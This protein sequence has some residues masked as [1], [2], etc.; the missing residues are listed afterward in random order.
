[1]PLKNQNYFIWFSTFYPLFF[2]LTV[3]DLQKKIA[4]I[5]TATPA[6]NANPLIFIQKIQTAALH[7]GAENQGI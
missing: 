7:S 6:L 4:A 3:K 1:M 5:N 2:L